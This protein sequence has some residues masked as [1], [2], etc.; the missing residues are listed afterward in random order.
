MKMRENVN[1]IKTI[2][3]ITIYHDVY[4]KYVQHFSS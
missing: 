3:G 2:K 1:K 4:I